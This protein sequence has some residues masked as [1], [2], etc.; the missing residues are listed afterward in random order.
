METTNGLGPGGGETGGRLNRECSEDPTRR[1]DFR[2]HTG[3]VEV[4]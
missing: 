4:D 3:L 2:L 1:R